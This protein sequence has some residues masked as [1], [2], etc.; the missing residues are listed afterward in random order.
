MATPKQE[1]ALRNL[2]AAALAW[3]L[4]DA[5]FAKVMD[6]KSATDIARA[7]A[8]AEVMSTLKSLRS[9]IRVL[10]PQLNPGKNPKKGA[11][12]PWMKALNVVAKASGAL[13]DAA[14]KGPPVG[15]TRVIDV[16]GE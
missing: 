16:Q 13:N 11:G 3:E 7:K 14:T 6:S 8:R 15:V 1:Q 12:F 4:A 9:A 10:R 2:V 5:R